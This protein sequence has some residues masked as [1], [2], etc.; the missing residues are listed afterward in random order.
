MSE[1]TWETD[2]KV[3]PTIEDTQRA[4][5]TEIAINLPPPGVPPEEELRMASL[6]QD[7]DHDTDDRTASGSA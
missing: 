1:P 3:H 4:I 6:L 2:G 5:D 7:A